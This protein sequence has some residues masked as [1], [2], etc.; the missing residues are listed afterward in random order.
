[1]FDSNKEIQQKV[2]KGWA[3]LEKLL[4]AVQEQ[5][6][7]T[8]APLA[9]TVIYQFPHADSRAQGL[10]TIIEMAKSNGLGWLMRTNDS[11]SKS[12]AADVDRLDVGFVELPTLTT[13]ELKPISEDAGDTS[14]LRRLVQRVLHW[15]RRAESARRE[16]DF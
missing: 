12:Q 1:M 7:N 14:R 16:S 15:Q 8:I 11:T 10:W 6:R 13:D 9:A 3:K 4:G 2:L 5:L